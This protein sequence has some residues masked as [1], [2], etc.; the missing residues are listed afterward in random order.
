M[1]A[2]GPDGLP[3]PSFMEKA[4]FYTSLCFGTTSILAVF[5][6]LFLIPF[7]VDPAISSLAADF[8]PEV[9]KLHRFK[10]SLVRK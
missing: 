8:D 2:L 10:F 1:G 7:I 5:G 3:I 4:K 9:C 6:F